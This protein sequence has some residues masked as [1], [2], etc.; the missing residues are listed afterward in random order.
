MVIPKP[1]FAEA[2][3]KLLGI[4][5]R[6]T[7]TFEQTAEIN[8]MIANGLLYCGVRDESSGDTTYARVLRK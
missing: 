2:F 4:G 6:W 8:E 5:E 1:G 3:P 7:G